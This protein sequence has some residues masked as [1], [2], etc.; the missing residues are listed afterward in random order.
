M[1]LTLRLR[2]P[3]ELLSSPQVCTSRS[4]MYTVRARGRISKINLIQISQV[5]FVGPKN[6][7]QIRALLHDTVKTFLCAVKLIL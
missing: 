3:C 5:T 7:S 1:I 2:I 6:S 4:Y